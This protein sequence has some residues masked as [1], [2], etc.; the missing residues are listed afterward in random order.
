M[1]R[2]HPGVYIEEI[3]SGVRP[4]EGISTST[5]C[6]IGKAESGAVGK[7]VLITNLQE[8]QKKFGGFLDDSYLAH[9][10]MQFF[11]NGGKKCYIVRVAT[12]GAM[13]AEIGI[14]DRKDSSGNDLSAKILTIKAASPGAWGNKLDIVI[15]DGRDD[16][17][18]EFNLELWKDRSDQQPAMPS[19][20]LETFEN[21]SINPNAVNFVGKIINSK[22][23]FITVEVDSGNLE[24]L[25]QS[26]LAK[27][28]SLSGTLSDIDL[29]AMKA[30]YYKFFIEIN[31]QF[32]NYSFF[33]SISKC[34]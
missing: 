3:P 15:K 2:L 25:K 19:Q 23:E 1:E 27:G 11:N 7:P 31:L 17:D 14:K 12:S 28:V 34:T 6:F 21:L 10:V 20:L 4:I 30:G 16:P 29:T 26:E 5:A 18:N 32:C 33:K 13:P 24:N 9:S 8:F 22:S